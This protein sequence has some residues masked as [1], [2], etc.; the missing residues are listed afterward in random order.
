[1]VEERVIKELET[2]LANPPK[3]RFTVF[4]LSAFIRADLWLNP[5]AMTS[6]TMLKAQFIFAAIC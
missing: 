5:L 6:L 4:V 3:R 1:L 2:E